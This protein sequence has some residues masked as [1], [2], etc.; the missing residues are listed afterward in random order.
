MNGVSVNAIERAMRDRHGLSGSSVRSMVARVRARWAE[1]ERENR[2]HYKAMAMR[3]IHAHIAAAR[4]SG[5]FSAVAQFERLLMEMQGTKEP[6]Q[7]KVD[8]SVTVS[9]SLLRVVSEMTPE[10]MRQLVEE[11]R[12]LRLAASGVR[13]LEAHGVAV[14][15]VAADLQGDG[16]G[17]SNGAR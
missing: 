15:A 5:H 3:R 8:V 1:E 4:E 2:Q 13:V 16:A 6:E 11:Q 17:V 9:E 14:P 10:R 7:V 12:R